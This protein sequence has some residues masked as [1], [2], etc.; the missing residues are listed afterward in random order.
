MDWCSLRVAMAPVYLNQYGRITKLSLLNAHHSHTSTDRLQM[1]HGNSH[2]FP[3]PTLHTA[4]APND[5]PRAWLY[6]QRTSILRFA[7]PTHACDRITQ[8]RSIVMRALTPTNIIAILANDCAILFR[9]TLVRSPTNLKNANI[10][11]AELHDTT[12]LSCIVRLACVCPLRLSS[13]GVS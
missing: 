13:D 3:P 10:I 4:R 2:I 1:M 7:T 5:A 9:R 6:L 12:P 8:E 11:F